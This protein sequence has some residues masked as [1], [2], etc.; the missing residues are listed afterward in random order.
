MPGDHE[1]IT[2]FYDAVAE[3]YGDS[4]SPIRTHCRLPAVQRLFPDVS[5]KRVLEAAC[6]TG[7]DAAWLAAQGADVLGVD[8]SPE[9]VRTARERFGDAAE[10]RKADLH[11]SLGFLEDGSVD[12]VS[13]QLTLSHIRDW[14]VILGEF[15]RVLTDDGVL[16]VSTDHPFRQFLLARDGEASDMDLYAQDA[17]PTVHPE[18]EPSN[19]YETERYDLAYGKEEPRVVS[20]FRR[21]MG[22]YLQ[23]FLESGFALE[24]VVEPTLTEEFREE[25][26]ETAEAF[27]HRVPDFLCF[28]AR[29]G[30]AVEH[31]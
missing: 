22:T 23:S 29:K 10:F 28:R 26:P 2:A 16:V 30:K 9:I 6:G 17:T 8:A 12:V 5:G 27:L 18:S 20:F 19:Y 25:N 21:S 7:T 4:E 31:P 14:D 15:A 3:T 24:E 13:S 11:E 1:S